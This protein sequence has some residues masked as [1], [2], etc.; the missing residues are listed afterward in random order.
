MRY[1]IQWIEEKVSAKGTKYN[2][3]T[4]I[5]E[6]G[7]QTEGVAIFDSFKGDL[8]AGRDVEGKL[9]SKDWQGKVSYTLENETPSG[10]NGG[11]RGGMIDHAKEKKAEMIGHAQEAKKDAIK[12]A[13]VN[14]N[15]VGIVKALIEAGG[16]EDLSHESIEKE[17]NYWKAYLD[18][19]WDTIKN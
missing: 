19:N 17:I 9:T 2:R 13:S 11:S 15:A 14:G 6:G 7:H 12:L 18:T 5:D 3:A 8:Q 4:L 10:A 16:F 1:K